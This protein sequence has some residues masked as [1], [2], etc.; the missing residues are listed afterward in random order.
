MS[1]LDKRLVSR[2]FAAAANEYDSNAEL[3][4]KVGLQLLNLYSPVAQK[5]VDLGCGTGFLTQQLV[6]NLPGAEWLALDLAFPMLQVCRERLGMYQ[7]VGYLCADA[8]ALPLADASVGQIYSNLAMQWCENLPVLFG[9]CRRVLQTGG[10]LVFSSFGPKTLHELKHAWSQVDEYAHVNEFKSADEIVTA[11]SK[12]G[13]EDI[14]LET[15]V[16]VSAYL[17]VMNLMRE[18]KGL[19]AHNI[20]SMRK[21]FPTTPKQLQAMIAAYQAGNEDNLVMATYEVLMVRAR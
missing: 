14:T 16:Y 9:D 10:Q 1:V 20:N 17:S 12:A 6:M 13:F 4:R 2:S 7:N 18:L 15:S 11:L 21:P 5:G 19:G 8:E 3:Q